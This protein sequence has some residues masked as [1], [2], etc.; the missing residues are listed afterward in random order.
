MV[1][2]LRLA[3]VRPPALDLSIPRHSRTQGNIY[4]WRHR[5]AETLCNL[6][7]IKGGYVKDRAQRVCRVRMQI[8]PE[9]LLGAL[10]E[11][12]ILTDELLELRLHI[13]DARGRELKLDHGHA[14]CLE[15]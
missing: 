8:T 6:C 14:R 10:V 7:K 15:V 11:V 2:L 3:P 13:D 4:A 5:K 12:I 1:L 9:A